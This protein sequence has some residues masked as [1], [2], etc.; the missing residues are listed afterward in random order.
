MAE[1]IVVADMTWT[2]VKDALAERP[3]GRFIG[4]WVELLAG[5]RDALSEAAPAL[6]GTGRQKLFEQMAVH[7]SLQNLASFPFVK[8]AIEAGQLRLHGAW[9]AIAEG[10]LEWLDAGSGRFEP[11]TS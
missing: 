8:A 5:I 11:V 7:Y 3:V 2:E 6:D 1:K 4:P 10:Q 9:F